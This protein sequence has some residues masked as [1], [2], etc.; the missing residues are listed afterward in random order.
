MLA[1]LVGVTAVPITTTGLFI[2][3]QVFDDTLTG[4]DL[5]QRALEDRR[6]LRGQRRMYW[7]AIEQYQK[8]RKAGEEV[9]KPDVND[10]TFLK[11]NVLVD[12]ER[13]VEDSSGA[14]ESEDA[15]DEVAPAVTKEEA[16]TAKELNT[17]DR[18]LLRR[19]TRAGFCPESL[20][21][22]R[23]QGFYG[24]C[25][26]LVGESVKAEPVV[27]LLNHNAY[28]YKK[29]RSSAPKTTGFKLRMQ[30]VEEAND[31]GTRRAGGATPGR[32]TTCVM[33]PNCLEPR[34]S[35]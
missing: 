12:T 30:M 18:G 27:G 6:R 13:S 28:L 29:F 1:L 5:R 11:K 26:A 15:K 22:F 16:L 32:P 34:Y 7:Q 24:L 10:P 4:T 20:K 25:R 9:E 14:K 23:I 8:K 3:Q 33:N 35:D 31:R 21:S 19:Y 17:Q 2:Q